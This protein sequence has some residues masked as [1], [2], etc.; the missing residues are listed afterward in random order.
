MHGNM[1]LKFDDLQYDL[2]ERPY[3]YTGLHP[4]HK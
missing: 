4:R 3:I 2:V 1:N